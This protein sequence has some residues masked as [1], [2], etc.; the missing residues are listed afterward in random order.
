MESSSDIKWLKAGDESSFQKFFETHYKALVG[1][2][3]K[4][5]EDI[6]E[7]EEVVQESFTKLWEKRSSIELSG[8]LSGY[9]FSMVRN[10]CL[11]KF[12]HEEVARKYKA[13]ILHTSN[14]FEGEASS[15]DQEMHHRLHQLI[16]EL[17]DQCQKIFQMSRFEDLKYAQIADKLDLSVKTVENQISK[18]LKIIR[19]DLRSVRSL[20]LIILLN[21][22]RNLSRGFYKASCLAN[23]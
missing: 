3:F 23:G 14:E 13:E 16:D 6:D 19:E 9:M 18:A 11:N 21:F 5:L 22:F 17:P 15:F 2:A 7:S 4:Y 20:H 12:K 10:V 8:Q 1:F